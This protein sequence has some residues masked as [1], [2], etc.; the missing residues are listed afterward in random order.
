LLYGLEGIRVVCHGSISIISRYAA[1]TKKIYSLDIHR[2]CGTAF[3]ITNSNAASLK[4]ILESSTIPKVI[5]DNHNDSDALFNQYRI[6]VDG[7]KGL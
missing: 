2:P 6:S 4:T 3:S 5:L 1:F 7:I